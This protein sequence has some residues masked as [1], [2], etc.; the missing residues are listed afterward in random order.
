MPGEEPD[1]H[2]GGHYT[3]VFPRPVFW[4][5]VRAE[6]TAVRW[7]ITPNTARCITLALPPTNWKCCGASK[8]WCG[9]RTLA[10]KD[11]PA[12]PDAIRETEHFRSDRYLGGSFQSLP[13]DLSEKRLCESR[14][15]GTLDDMNN[16][17]RPEVFAR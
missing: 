4:T 1:A 17:D 6:R 10:P 2:F 13:V 7:N 14:C 8:A 9:R 3:T 11:R 12:I 15:F 5:H 16:W